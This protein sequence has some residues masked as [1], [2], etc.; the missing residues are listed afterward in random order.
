MPAPSQHWTTDLRAPAAALPVGSIDCHFHI[1]GS[2][3]EYRLR[4]GRGYTPVEASFESYVAAL[5]AQHEALGIS[6]GLIAH[7]GDAYGSDNTVTRK[8]L[9][10]LGPTYRAT[11]LIDFNWP[12][13]VL[14]ELAAQG[15][16]G[17]R[18]NVGSASMHGAADLVGL[19]PRFREVGWHFSLMLDMASMHSEYEYLS[20]LGV[21]V[22]VEHYGFPDPAE[23]TEAEGFQALLR[24]VGEGKATVKLSSQFRFSREADPYRDTWKFTRAL[25]RANPDGVVWGSDWPFIAFGGMMPDAA[26]LLDGLREA[27]GDEAVFRRVM[28]ENPARLLG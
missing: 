6:G 24:L 28:V 21:P 5:R 26:R 9:E 8:A 19:A 3:Q 2:P 14:V 22:V 13:N 16:I 7:P 18:V 10:I 15:F 25:C 12:V 4:T 27:I 17:A 23:G 11:A 20:N 1:F